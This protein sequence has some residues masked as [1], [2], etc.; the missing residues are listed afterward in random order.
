MSFAVSGGESHLGVSGVLEAVAQ[1]LAHGSE[2]DQ[3][4]GHE[5]KLLDRADAAVR[6]RWHAPKLSSRQAR[7][8]LASAAAAARC[9]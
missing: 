3:R 9:R 1:R 6:A 8:H 4:C 5:C 7:R 2:A